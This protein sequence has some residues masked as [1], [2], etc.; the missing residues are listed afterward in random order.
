MNK[1]E[2]VKKFIDGT[3]HEHREE[4][5]AVAG[6]FMTLIDVWPQLTSAIGEL[7]KIAG[8]GSGPETYA[9]TLIGAEIVKLKEDVRKLTALL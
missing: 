1:Q 3:P 4:L 9:L 5:R 6:D 2:K 7:N 8:P